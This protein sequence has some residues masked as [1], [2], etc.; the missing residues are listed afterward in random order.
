MRAWLAAKFGDPLDVLELVEVPRPKPGPDQVLVRIL[1]A[2]LGLPD[3]MSVQGRYGAIPTP[4]VTP[5]QEVVA[6][7]EEVGG[8]CPFAPGDRVNAFTMYREGSGGLADYALCHVRDLYPLSEAL[9]DT[10]GAGFLVPYHTAYVGLVTRGGLKSGETLLVLGGAGGTG[11]AA[12]QLG[13]ALG[14]TVIA[15]A[16]GQAKANF[17]KAQGADHVVDLLTEDLISTVKAHTGGR[18]A[19][20]VY[21]PVG[22]EAYTQA[23]GC[24]AMNGRIVLIGYASGRWGEVSAYDMV[25][26][27][28]SAV[29]ALLG[30]RT[31]R[32]KEEAITAL[33]ALADA[34]RI[35]VPVSGVHGMEDVPQ[36]LGG[37]GREV[38]GKLIIKI[39]ER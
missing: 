21:D 10:E 11:S 1:A 3:L 8:E 18:G 12:I 19:N 32:D 28:Y 33:T 30:R 37:L 6:I 15:T 36:V 26:K 31:R 20:I 25:L 39:A 27:S 5:G 13:K 7:I 34:G 29:G 17:C 4:P 23:T 16:R 9:S 22:G 38:M 24:V 35:S 2:G 14:A